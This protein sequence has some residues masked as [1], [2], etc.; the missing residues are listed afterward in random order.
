MP[1]TSPTAKVFITGASSGIGRALAQHYARQ[2]AVLGLVGRDAQRLQSVVDTLP[3]PHA[4]HCYVADVRDTAALRNAAR[5]FIDHFGCPDIVIASAGISAGVHTE[6]ADDLARF[7]A[8]M[9]TNW[10]AMIATFQP[11]IAPMRQR[12]SGV[13]AGIASLAGVRGLP[14]HG[15][16]SASKAAVISTLESLRVELRRDG[17]GVVTIA[18][19]Y[20]RTPM[21]DGNPFPMPFLMD[22]DAFARKAARAIARRRRFAVY[23]WPMRIVSALLHVLPRWLYDAAFARAPRKPRATANETPGKARDG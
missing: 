17:I 22:V 10:L 8:I 18:P 7:E 12:G 15:A 4:A 23:P 3:H 16:Y 21:T 1:G 19:G 2:G 9:D 20:I 11:F 13:L 6:D 14:G 5:A